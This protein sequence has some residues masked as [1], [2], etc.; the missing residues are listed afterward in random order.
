MNEL[1]TLSKYWAI[2]PDTL[3][4]MHSLLSDK[5]AGISFVSG[6]SQTKNKASYDIK[7]GVAIIN[8]QGVITPKA[9]L[10][11]MIFGGTSL[12]T[13]G[14]NLK[15]ALEDDEVK[16]ILF[17]VD[18]PGGVAL[19]TAETAEIIHQAKTI[20]QKPIWSYVGRNCCSAAYWLAS[21][22]EKIIV[23][24]SALLGS[25]G[26]VSTIPI[27]EQAGTDGYRNIEIVSSNAKNKRPDPRTQE[28][29]NEIRQELDSI[30]TEFITSISKYRGL[31]IELIKSDF[32]QGGVMIGAKVT[33]VG[34][35]DELGTFEET[36]AKMSVNNF[37]RLNSQNSNFNNNIGVKTM[38]EN[39][40][41][42]SKNIVSAKY[43]KEEFPEIVETLQKESFDNGVQEGLEAGK[44]VGFEN[45]KLEGAK[46]ER[47]RLSAI[48][49]AALNGY[50]DL[51]AEAKKDSKMTAEKL[52]L[53]I[54]EAEKSKGNSYLA[55]IKNAET[56]LPQI[57]HSAA[58][59]IKDKTAIDP[60]TPV[61]ERAEA[62]WN[63]NTA[64]R[65]EFN[66]DKEAFMAFYKA[67]ENGQIKLKNN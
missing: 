10:F 22:T 46:A 56:K 55:S 37:K 67:N 4:N 20:G 41:T 6:S 39:Q 28:G 31:P 40:N 49:R 45:G 13:I 29:L 38:N 15:T 61:E 9:D 7:N 5:R 16:S 48:D 19:G 53:R 58:L 26:V 27:Q 33:E 12:E 42:I 63:S 8:I 18:S 57:D 44:L 3:K 50:E 30:E 52:A 23:H 47:E 59:E 14:E 34:M 36:I 66:G 65:A 32:G 43:L 11:T 21:A 1:S 25:I 2:E 24:R 64:I 62:E 60:N 17:N 51:V 54:I 35:A